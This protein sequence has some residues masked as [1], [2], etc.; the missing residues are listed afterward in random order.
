M[1]QDG[2]VVL[3]AGC[4]YGT[5]SFLF[6]W[7][8]ARVVSVDRVPAHVEVAAKRRPYFEDVLGRR[9]DIRFEVADLEAI[10][11]DETP[12]TM[13]WLG[14]VLAAVGD[15]EDLLRRIHRATAPRGCVMVSDM[16]LWNPMFLLGEHRRRSRARRVYPAFDAECDFVAMLSRRGRK[17]ARYFPG[18]AGDQ[19]DDVQ[20]FTPVTLSALLRRTGFKTLKPRYSGL[21]PPAFGRLA[22]PLE[23]CVRHAP[24]VRRMAYFYL[25]TGVR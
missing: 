22:A 8:G 2:P 25:I 20:F 4:G 13:T 10:Q 16:N 18:E 23:R 6:A 15:Q 1:S 24:G 21:V 14:S 3:D 19:F 12:L 17:G 9:L 11:P 5:E 7:S